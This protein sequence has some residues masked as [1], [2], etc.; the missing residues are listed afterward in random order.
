MDQIISSKQITP[1]Y[2][3]KKYFLFYIIV[4]LIA[5]S[6]YGGYWYGAKQGTQPALGQKQTQGGQVLHT[7]KPLPS[8]VNKDVDFDLFWDVWHRTKND[9][10]NKNIPDTKLFY[11]A[12][13]GIVSALDDPY[14][15]FFDPQKAKEFDEG[16][17]GSFDG[18]GAELG[19]KKNQL[20]I[21]ATLPNMPAEKAGLRSG[22][23]ILAIDKKST[24]EMIIDD[25]VS[26]IRGKKGTTVM[27]TIY[28]DGEPQ[29]RDIT[30]ARDKI[31]IEP[32]KSEM[33]P[34]GVGYIRIVHFT[35][36]TGEKFK[37]AVNDL[38]SKHARA[39]I[40]DLRND[41]GGYLDAAVDVA[42]YWVD[43]QVV[44][45][46]K[47]NDSKQDTYKGRGVAP[48]KD[49]PTVVLVNRGSASASEIVAG[50]LQDYGKAVLIGETTFGK[51]SVQDVQKLRDGSALKLTIAKWL[52]PKGRTIQDEGI[53]PDIMV[54]I[55]EKDYKDKKDPQL[56]KALEELKKKVTSN[57]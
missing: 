7:E 47:Y 10:I 32:I 9:G 54:E 36:D 17:S 43:G 12:I 34:D 44:V 33:K 23:K 2:M 4:A 50:A 21:I 49:M 8:Y 29:E 3:L 16:L 37:K 6:F 38:L 31:V 35:Q 57:K 51:G 53:K 40:L 27:L 5:G 25:A 11:G 26:R 1:G 45:I 39:L 18:I 41:P 56:E 46:E 13:S 42:G 24:T 52:T 48:L 20:V 15:V 14:S 28:R 19:M 30:I 55:T 22:D